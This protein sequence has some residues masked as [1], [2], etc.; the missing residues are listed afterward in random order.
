MSSGYLN[1]AE[2]EKHIHTLSG[3]INTVSINST[4]M[5]SDNLNTCVINKYTDTLVVTII[6]Q[7]Q[8]GKFLRMVNVQLSRYSLKTIYIQWKY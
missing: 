3:H 7:Q 5:F 2:I 1:T 6:E 4:Y 8:H